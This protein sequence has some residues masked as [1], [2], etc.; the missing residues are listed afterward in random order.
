MALVWT[1]IETMFLG[2]VGIVRCTIM[3]SLYT[4][5]ARAGGCGAWIS[6]SIIMW[7]DHW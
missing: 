5:M 6:S 2:V 1:P 4:G 7:K 3:L